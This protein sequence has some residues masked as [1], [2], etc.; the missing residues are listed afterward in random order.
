MCSGG[1]ED[2]KRLFAPSTFK[3]APVVN[4][5]AGLRRKHTAADTCNQG[6]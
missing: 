5:D 4:A 6:K 2:E 3:H 1:I